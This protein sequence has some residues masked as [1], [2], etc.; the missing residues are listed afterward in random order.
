M[1]THAISLIVILALVLAGAIAPARSEMY[2]YRDAQGNVCFTDNLAQIPED[3][4][5]GAL[6]LESIAA[7]DAVDN[8]ADPQQSAADNSEDTF[9]SDEVVV[10]DQTIAA[11]N[12]RKKAL[13]EEFSGLM[14]EKYALLKEKQKLDGL[15]GRDVKA[16][17]AYE[18]K[19]ADLNNRIADYA[20]RRD[21]FQ[22][23]CDRVEQALEPTSPEGEEATPYEG[24]EALAE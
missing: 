10:D 19:V 3:Q 20:T 22:K 12:D 2:K 16:R 18:G 6:T 9:T 13:D 21:A 7:E 1:K 4:R 15:A 8:K 14:A 24:D 17:Q 5:S 23:A 11:L